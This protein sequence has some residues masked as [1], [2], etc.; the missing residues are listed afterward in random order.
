MKCVVLDSFTRAVYNPQSWTRKI[1]RL[2]YPNV[3]TM[4]LETKRHNYRMHGTLENASPEIQL[5]ALRMTYLNLRTA[6]YSMDMM[7]AAYY[8]L[9]NKKNEWQVNM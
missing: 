9:R 2:Y 8:D 4:E 3:Q 1:I 7:I 6:L 5:R